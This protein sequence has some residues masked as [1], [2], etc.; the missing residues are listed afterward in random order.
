MKK[1]L[2]SVAVVL[3]LCLLTAIATLFWQG[4]V[5]C[6]RELQAKP[7]EAAVTAYTGDRD[8]VA[9]EDIDEDFVNAVISVEDKRFFRRNG[10]DFIALCR[11]LY[12]N[13]L[14]KGMVEGGSTISEQ[15]AK[16]LYFGGYVNGLEEKMGEIFVLFELEKTYSKEELFALYVNMNYYGDS[17]WGIK[18]A[19][20]GYYDV[21]CSDLTLAQAAI[22]AGLPNA[23][24]VYQLSTGYELAK[25][26]Q[27]W[28]L[29]TM[30]NNGYITEKEAAEALKED[31]RPK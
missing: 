20:D 2:T 1:K 13:F 17:Y 8:Y 19:A 14:A 23:P 26:R 27:E 16:N 4:Y 22:L 31:V 30:C 5:R 21:S 10:Y 25:Q 6:K 12:H 18:A 28:V 24:S 29:Q 11:A 15:I 3:F 7:L 9:Y